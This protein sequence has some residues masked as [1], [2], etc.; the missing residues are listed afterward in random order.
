M[1]E[2]KM[3]QTNAAVAA[4]SELHPYTVMDQVIDQL[5]TRGAREGKYGR[6]VLRVTHDGR[7]LGHVRMRSIVSDGFRIAFYGLWFS[8][9]DRDIRTA[10]PIVSSY[11]TVVGVDLDTIYGTIRIDAPPGLAVPNHRRARRQAFRPSR[12]AR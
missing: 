1:R 12:T 6:A 7:N 10:R 4:S 5:A 3:V 11:G 2:I 9:D 8:L